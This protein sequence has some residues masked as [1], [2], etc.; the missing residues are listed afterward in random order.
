MSQITSVAGREGIF[1][2]ITRVFTIIC[3]YYTLYTLL[4]VFDLFNGKLFVIKY[5]KDFL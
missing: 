1:Q 5:G 2:S 3:Y 4:E